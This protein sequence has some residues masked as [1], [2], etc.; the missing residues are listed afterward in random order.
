MTYESEDRYARRIAASEPG[1]DAHAAVAEA[2]A[3]CRE[4]TV[5]LSG[6]GIVTFEYRNS[7]GPTCTVDDVLERMTMLDWRNACDSLCSQLLRKGGFD[8]G[9]FD[10]PTPLPKVT[11]VPED[12]GTDVIARVGVT[13]VVDQATY[14]ALVRAVD[15][16]DTDGDLTAVCYAPEFITGCDNAVS[17]GGGK[18]TCTCKTGECPW[19][20][21]VKA[22]AAKNGEETC[23][24]CDV[25]IK[26]R[27][28][29]GKTVVTCPECGEIQPLCN[30]CSRPEKEQNACDD[31]ELLAKCIELNKVRAKTRRK[32]RE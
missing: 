4:H 8:P 23:C 29:Q 28:Q 17:S 9:R 13:F 27:V 12:E 20:C 21:R 10:W 16:M 2:V 11:F 18:D 26:Y 24:N 19:S 30:E 15:G 1:D 5:V 22:P 25:Q 7:F 14:S 3:E 6:N 32:E 31:C